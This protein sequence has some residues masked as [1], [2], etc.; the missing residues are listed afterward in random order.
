MTNH[1]KISV[2]AMQKKKTVYHPWRGEMTTWPPEPDP[3]NSNH[4]GEPP[5]SNALDEIFSILLFI[6]HGS[7]FD[8]FLDFWGYRLKEG[9]L[10]FQTVLESLKMTSCSKSYGGFELGP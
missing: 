4:S 10:S 2:P 5:H 9:T 6:I 7:N 1:K 8:L 3:V